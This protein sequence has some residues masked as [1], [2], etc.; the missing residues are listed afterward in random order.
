VKVVRHMLG[1]T[2]PPTYAQAWPFKGQIDRWQ[3]IDFHTT[4][5]RIW[6]GA[7]DEK[8]DAVDDLSRGGFH[9]RGFHGVTPETRESCH[10]FW[11]IATKPHPARDDITK[12]VVDQTAKTF[13]EDQGII[14]A[15]WQ[16]QQRFGFRPQI[17]I[18]VDAAPNR[19]RRVIEKLARMSQE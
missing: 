14:Q 12:L 17:S 2:P 10:Y 8:T 9:M 15:Q 1:S 16:N 3:E 11:T 18:H 6:T 13:L 4:H 5:V 19:A 7:V